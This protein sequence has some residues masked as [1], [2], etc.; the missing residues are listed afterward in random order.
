MLHVLLPKNL[1]NTL[2][3]RTLI[4]P[5]IE[6]HRFAHITPAIMNVMLEMSNGCGN[7]FVGAGVLQITGW[8]EQV[9]TAIYPT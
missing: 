5:M 4:Q 3:K 1:T 6:H 2:G 8:F 9:P 7:E